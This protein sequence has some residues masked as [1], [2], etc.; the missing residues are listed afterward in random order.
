V[1]GAA[2][3]SIRDWRD[4]AAD[5]KRDLADRGWRGIAAVGHSV[6]A[7]CT[8]MAASDDPGLFRAVV[9]IDPVLFTGPR[10]A[11]WSA[12]RRAGL[13]RWIP[14]ARGAARRRD[15]F[16]TREEARAYW[17]GKQLFATWDP[18][19]LDDYVEAGLVP[20]GPGGFTLA[21]SGAW[22]ERV[23]ETTPHDAWEAA[24]RLAVPVLVLRGED[25]DTFTRAAAR[26]FLAACPAAVT[27]EVPGTTH[28]LP[29]ERPEAVAALVS[30]FLGC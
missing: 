17:G 19:C 7:V 11:V 9:L 13:G 27:V 1:A 12:M 23:F 10:L 22:E 24:G 29:M 5:L 20:A 4:L 3:A 14:I 8:M 26:R 18:R 28:L 2:P 16:P 30:R 25:S 6:G 15:E 21:W